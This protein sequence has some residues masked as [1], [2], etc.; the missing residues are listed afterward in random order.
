MTKTASNP[1][2]EAKKKLQVHTQEKLA[3]ASDKIITIPNIITF[4]RILLVPVFATMMYLGHDKAAIILIV[5][6]SISDFLDG[7]IARKTNSVTKVGKI[8]DPCADRLMIFILL[9]MLVVRNVI[10]FWALIAIFVRET[11]LFFEYGA[12]ILNGKKT[13]EVSFTGKA[14]TAG[15][16]VSLPLFL[17]H[18]ALQNWDTGFGLIAF[19]VLPFITVILFFI[20]LIF[21]WTAGVQYTIKA[22]Q[23]LKTVPAKKPVIISAFITLIVASTLILLVIYFVKPSNSTGF[24]SI[25]LIVSLFRLISQ[26]IFTYS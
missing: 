17:L 3:D 8:L 14:G 13:I 2:S 4:F 16:L 10:P 20:S 18:S 22:V 9:I 6:S 19:I 1:F 7:Y 23:I 15:L 26:V 11:I 5:I 24:A 21:Y 25:D 12:L